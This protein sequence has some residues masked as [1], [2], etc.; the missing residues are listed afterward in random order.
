MS[1]T[2]I[3]KD[4]ERAAR[5]ELILDHAGRLLLR[6]GYQN[7]NLD[8]LAEA[9][10][11]SKGTIYL[12]FKT[13]EDLVLAIA[14]R[15]A[16]QRADLFERG[17]KFTGKTRER[18][19]SIGFA[20]CQFALMHRDYFNIEMM[21]KSLSFWEKASE[22]HRRMHGVQA[23]RMFHHVNTIAQEAVTGADLPP[24]TRAQD[25]TLSLISITLGSHVAAM[26]PDIQMLCAIDDPI[27]ALRR[28][29]D[30]ILDGWFWKPLLKD[31]DYAATDRR[32][33]KEIFPEAKWLQ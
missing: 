5:E 7:L 17:S 29:Q 8:E 32:I 14:T 11:Y 6:D 20:C 12:H 10:E 25:V 23:G 4:R 19:R 13:K 9:I 26:Q 33:Q 27:S 31:W 2:H 15:I 3:R 22:E 30:L 28:N 16:R 24:R 18:M 21:L 1:V